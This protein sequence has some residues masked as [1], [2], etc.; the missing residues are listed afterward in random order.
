MRFKTKSGAHC[1]RWLLHRDL[2]GKHRS[3]CR[4][5]A[6]AE[7]RRDHA[8]LYRAGR[9]DHAEDIELKLNARGVTEMLKATG[10]EFSV[11]APTA[12]ANPRNTAART[13]M[14][15]GGT[16]ARRDSL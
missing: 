10:A 16:P 6:G 12:G 2:A 3:R 7:S 1:P 13:R 4:G 5:R 8:H 9:L 11:R 15:P 14:R